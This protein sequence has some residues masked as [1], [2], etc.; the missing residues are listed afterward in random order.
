MHKKLIMACM[1]IAAFAAFVLP[2]AA[3]ASPVVTDEGKILAAPATLLGTST[4]SPTFTGAFSVV[5][6]KAVL[7]GTLTKNTGSKI[8]GTIPVGKATYTGTGTGGDC[9][10]AFGST[11]VEVNSELCLASGAGDTFSVTGCGANLAFSLE[12]TGLGKCKYSTASVSGTFVT[13]ITPATLILI[14]QEAKLSEGNFFCPSSGKLDQHFDLY[15]DNAAETPL[16]I[17]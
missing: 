6:S 16:T 14:E 2:T 8:E 4:G 17:S 3:S 12:V 11:R 1:A 13:N 7:T 9:T 5:C 10:S 15:T